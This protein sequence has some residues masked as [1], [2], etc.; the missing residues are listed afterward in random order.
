MVNLQPE[1]GPI[2]GQFEGQ[3]VTSGLH[4][5]SITPLR[6][7]SGLKLVAPPKNPLLPTTGSAFLAREK[8]AIVTDALKRQILPSANTA[9]TSRKQRGSLFSEHHPGLLPLT[10]VLNTTV[11]QHHWPIPLLLTAPTPQVPLASNHPI[12][13]PHLPRSTA[14]HHRDSGHNAYATA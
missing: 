1:T 10:P 4:C 9:G 5:R 12:H 2:I 14:P 11:W 6:G 7:W 3:R 8:S 13:S